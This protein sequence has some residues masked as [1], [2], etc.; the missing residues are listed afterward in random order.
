MKREDTL[1]LG[2]LGYVEENQTSPSK[3]VA[4]PHSDNTLYHLLLCQ[5]AGYLRLK[6]VNDALPRGHLALLKN[7]HAPQTKEVAGVSCVFVERLTFRGH[8]RLAKARKK[9]IDFPRLH[10]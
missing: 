5:D 4:I 7:P 3:P 2:L 1:I 9:R 6:T 10:F 8:E